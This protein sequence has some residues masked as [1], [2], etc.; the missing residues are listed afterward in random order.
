[1]RLNLHLKNAM[2]H[3]EN[4]LR[5]LREKIDSFNTYDVVMYSDHIYFNE[6]LLLMTNYVKS[7]TPLYHILKN[8]YDEMTSCR[9]MI[10]DNI[11]THLSI[12]K[13]LSLIKH[14]NFDKI[15]KLTNIHEYKELIHMSS[16]FNCIFIHPILLPEISNHLLYSFSISNTNNMLGICSLVCKQW[17][18]ITQTT[19]KSSYNIQKIKWPRYVRSCKQQTIKATLRYWINYTTILYQKIN[20]VPY[21]SKLLNNADSIINKLGEICLK[22]KIIH[23]IIESKIGISYQTRIPTYAIDNSLSKITIHSLNYNIINQPQTQE[24]ELLYKLL[25]SHVPYILTYHRFHNKIYLNI[26]ATQ[27]L[28]VFGPLFNNTTCATLCYDVLTYLINQYY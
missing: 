8:H 5:Y 3:F 22:H 18:N 10:R 15:R 23:K 21:R 17:Y 12:N 7:L 24:E 1:M 25:C 6:I 4:Q 16:K 2:K 11:D 19:Q 13:L 28:T 26:N 14:E 9:T 27:L 20:I